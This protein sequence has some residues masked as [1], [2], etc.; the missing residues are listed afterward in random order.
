M[1]TDTHLSLF[2]CLLGWGALS[3]GS[4]RSDGSDD[5]IVCPTCPIKVATIR[6]SP[7]DLAEVLGRLRGEPLFLHH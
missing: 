6:D 5:G 4:D 1:S 3:D 7:K 2:F